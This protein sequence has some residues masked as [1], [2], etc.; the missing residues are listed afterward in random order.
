MALNKKKIYQMG[1]VLARNNDKDFH[2]AAFLWRNGRV[3]NISTNGS[4]QSPRFKRFITDREGNIVTPFCNHAE[5]LALEYAIAGDTLE[6]IRW[7]KNGSRA[8]AKPC[9]H[10]RRRIKHFG[11]TVRYT[12]EYGEWE[13]LNENS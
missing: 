10:C 2:L 4:K 7:L 12:N 8:N 13:Y 9:V 1:H 11:V 3:I 6:V 5:M